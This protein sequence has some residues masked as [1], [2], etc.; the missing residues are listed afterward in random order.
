[1]GNKLM[2][3]SIIIL[4]AAAVGL[5]TSV[6]LEAYAHE[7]IYLLLMKITAGLFGVGGPLLGWSIARRR[8]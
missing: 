8:Q 5:V 3:L 1:M 2:I 7:S 4:T 6:C